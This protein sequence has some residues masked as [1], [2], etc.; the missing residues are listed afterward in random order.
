M[1]GSQK[2]RWRG[3]GCLAMRITGICLN[4][5][6]AAPPQFTQNQ[7]SIQTTHFTKIPSIRFLVRF[8]NGFC[9]DLI[10]PLSKY[11]LGVVFPPTL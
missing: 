5:T 3:L 10:L 4:Y 1:T 6:L 7:K 8:F 9:D 2:W 11:P